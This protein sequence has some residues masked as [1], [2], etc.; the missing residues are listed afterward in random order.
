MAQC[1]G[2]TTDWTDWTVLRSLVLQEHQC[3]KSTDIIVFLSCL[4]AAFENKVYMKHCNVRQMIENSA[5]V[6]PEIV[7]A[8]LGEA[9]FLE[10]LDI[11]FRK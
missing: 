3:K 7:P 2:H 8:C 10:L 4:E 9:S 5:L 6:F 11:P 1:N